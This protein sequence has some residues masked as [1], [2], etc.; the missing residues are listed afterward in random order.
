MK[1]CIDELLKV[2]N[3][4]IEIKDDIVQALCTD[5]AHHKQWYLLRIAKRLKLDIDY[6]NI[7]EGIAP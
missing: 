2:A 3:D 1:Q 5:G 7:D 6:S 4:L